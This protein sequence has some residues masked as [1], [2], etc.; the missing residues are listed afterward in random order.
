MLG[1]DP[2]LHVVSPCYRADLTHLLFLRLLKPAARLAMLSHTTALRVGWLGLCPAPQ[3]GHRR[4]RLPMRMPPGALS[5]LRRSHLRPARPTRPAGVA[6]TLTP[7]PGSDLGCKVQTPESLCNGAT[8]PHRCQPRRLATQALPPRS[9][10]SLCPAAPTDAG[11]LQSGEV[12]GRKYKV[13]EVLGR[14]GN[15]VTYKV[16]G[17]GAALLL[18]TRFECWQPCQAGGLAECTRGQDELDLPHCLPTACAVPGP[19]QRR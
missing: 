13:Q 18:M 5:A 11:E 6:A 15:A 4:P 12:I 17:L 7:L 8:A 9:H 16:T 1:L 2:P 10:A 3:A 19:V 14:G